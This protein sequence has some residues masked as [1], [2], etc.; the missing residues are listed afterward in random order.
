MG[1]PNTNPTAEKK[2]QTKERHS[3]KKITTH[4]S[5]S[6]CQHHTKQIN[7]KNE[8]LVKISIFPFFCLL[9]WL[10]KKGSQF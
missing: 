6:L 1:I 4:N 7:R 9:F 10:N 8:F 2:T 5:R 3:G